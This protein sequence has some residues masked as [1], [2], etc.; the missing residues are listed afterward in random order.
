MSFILRE[1]F[2]NHGVYA[3]KLSDV[4]RHIDMIARYHRNFD[5]KVVKLSNRIERIFSNCVRDSNISDDFIS[6]SEN[7]G[8][9][10]LFG[11]AIKYFIFDLY[12]HFF[13]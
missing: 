7:N 2:R 4:I 11:E 3:D 8:S 12:V 1:H 5:P 6:V 10:A 9:F 13:E